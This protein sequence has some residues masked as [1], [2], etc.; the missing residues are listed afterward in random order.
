[1]PQFTKVNFSIH[2]PT[3]DSVITIKNCILILTA[4]AVG[5]YFT[6][7]FPIILYLHL[8]GFSKSIITTSLPY[9][10]LKLTR[11][12]P[13]SFLNLYSCCDTQDLGVKDTIQLELNGLESI[14]HSTTYNMEN[15]PEQGA[16]GKGKGVMQAGSC[17][18]G[19]GSSNS[20]TSNVKIK[21]EAGSSNSASSNL[22][23]KTEAESSNSASSNVKI[24]TEAIEDQK[25][26]RPTVDL[27]YVTV[28]NMVTGHHIGIFDRL[29]PSGERMRSLFSPT[30]PNSISPTGQIGI[31]G[32]NY[33]YLKKNVSADSSLHVE[34]P[35]PDS[36]G[37]GIWARAPS[38]NHRDLKPPR[39][40]LYDVK[41]CNKDLI[42]PKSEKR[43]FIRKS[44]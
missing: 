23:I 38:Q 44:R 18:K 1:M 17:D 6:N 14:K 27:G 16:P 34:V 43:I 29:Q 10:F 26:I 8:S 39:G 12:I 2:D 35:A 33:T 15:H 31:N 37:R 11:E 22:N 4:S 32:T 21:T 25:Q 24:K 9:D 30:L 19:S 40:P 41:S 28:P 13:S 20:G 3:L 36:D 7:L 42:W 5:Y